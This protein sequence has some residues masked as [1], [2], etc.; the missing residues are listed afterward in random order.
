MKIKFSKEVAYIP[1]WNGN[2][3][4]PDEEQVKVKLKPIKVGDLLLIIDAMGERRP[5]NKLDVKAVANL[6]KEAG[7]LIPTY[8]DVTGLTSE[9]GSPITSGEIIQYP[10]FMELAG[11]LLMQ[12]ANLSTP[13]D[14]DTKNLKTQPA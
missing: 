14:D 7:H 9:D 1:E 12:L 3:E 2:K 4:L 10:Y 6:L 8:T 5:D 11:E 13:G